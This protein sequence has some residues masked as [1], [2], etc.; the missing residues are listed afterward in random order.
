[1]VQEVQTGIWIYNETTLETIEAVGT[2]SRK[3]IEWR[4]TV[5]WHY[6]SRCTAQWKANR[7]YT[8]WWSRSSPTLQAKLSIT[9]TQW[10]KRFSAVDWGI[11]VP[12][13]WTYELTITWIGSNTTYGITISV[14]KWDD[15][16]GKRVFIASDNTNYDPITKSVLVD[17]GKFD[18]LNVYYDYYYS[19]SAAGASF[20][21]MTTVTIQQI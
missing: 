16:S 19:G 21:E 5:G 18:T 10:K 3:I 11:C 2:S 20:G 12:E 1:M 7:S 17:L 4:Q 15:T 8:S 13:A 6:A 14:Y 9:S